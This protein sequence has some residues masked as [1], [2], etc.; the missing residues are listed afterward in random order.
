MHLQFEFVAR[1][2]NPKPTHNRLHTIPRSLA[3]R[4]RDLTCGHWVNVVAVSQ[5]HLFR[6]ESEHVVLF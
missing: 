5:D 4:F 1:I 2:P 6:M 3:L